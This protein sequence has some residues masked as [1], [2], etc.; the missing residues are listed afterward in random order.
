MESMPTKIIR[1]LAGLLL[2]VSGLNKFFPMMPVPEHNEAA[3][4]FLGALAASGYVFPIVGFVEAA[5]GAAF[6]A[7]RFVALA[8]VVLA[9]ISV[10]IVLVHAVLD[11]S[12]AG[13]GF[14][15]G[16]ANAYL[17]AVHFPKYQ[18]MLMPR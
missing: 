3:S 8:A 17:L 11:S 12:G 16:L 1:V 4:A 5:C 15:V 6:V 7:G 13:P 18:D 9:P 10:N 2:F 14:F